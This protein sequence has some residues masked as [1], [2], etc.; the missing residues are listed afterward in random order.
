MQARAGFSVAADGAYVAAL[1]TTMTPDLVNEG[2][3][4]EFVRRVQDSRKQADL[5][6]ADRIVLSYTA[7][8]KLKDAV[9]QFKTY[10]MDETL[11][12][13]LDS[14]HMPNRLPNLSDEFD[15]ETL[16]IWLEKA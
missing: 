8:E 1:V 16:T 6:I 10:I 7:S 11:A 9:V 3:A 13:S 12:I 4:R 2:L 14:E 15:G 5:D